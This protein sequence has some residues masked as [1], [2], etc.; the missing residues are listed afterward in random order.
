MA[1]WLTQT[2]ITNI[3]SNKARNSEREREIVGAG[4]E[5]ERLVLRKKHGRP[6]KSEQEWDTSWHSVNHKA[7]PQ[8]LQDFSLEGLKALPRSRLMPLKGYLPQLGI[9][10]PLTTA[11]FLRVWPIELI[12]SLGGNTWQDRRE[13]KDV[14][15]EG[16]G[17]IIPDHVHLIEILPSLP[18]LKFRFPLLL[19][20][21][22]LL[23]IE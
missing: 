3:L 10:V 12:E 1:V 23:L 5:R 21:W 9:G 16:E 11:L 8:A 2:K 4:R 20:F 15:F 13:S 17:N 7:G 14:L 19:C 22:C 18:T 6:T